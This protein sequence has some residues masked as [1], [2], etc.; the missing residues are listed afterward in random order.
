MSIEERREKLN[1]AL[2]EALEQRR[3]VSK[4]Q[5]GWTAAEGH[6]EEWERLDKE[7]AR[8]RDELIDLNTPKCA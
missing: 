8:I 3:A 4:S 1:A 7:V 6:E 5:Y 2:R